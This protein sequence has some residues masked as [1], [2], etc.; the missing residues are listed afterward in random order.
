MGV[1]VVDP[2]DSVTIGLHGQLNIPV[3]LHVDIPVGARFP[4]TKADSD[5]WYIYLGSDGYRDAVPA[6]GRGL[7]PIRA[8]ILPDLVG[9]QADAYAM[10]RG[11]GIQHWPRG[12][13]I[14]IADGL[15]IAFGFGL[16]YIIGVK[17]I[18][19]AEVHMRR[20]SLAGHASADAGGLRRSR[21]LAEPRSVLDRRRR[22]AGASEGRE[23]RSLHPCA[24]L[25]THRSVLHGR[26]RLRRAVD[27][28]RTK[29]GGAA[30]TRTRSTTSRTARWQA[31]SRT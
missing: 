5:N 23:R 18:A 19:W 10:L 17:P 13:Q 7:G 14:T 9:A 4:T 20:R 16:E 29:A 28:Q 30:P 22:H 25:R 24:P 3:V 27:Q 15:V 11:R 2:A 8:E 1:V 21:R 12:G 31:T 6:D 26:R